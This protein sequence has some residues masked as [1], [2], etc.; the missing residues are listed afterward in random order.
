MVKKSDPSK[1]PSD[2]FFALLGEEHIHDP[3]QI[4]TVEANPTIEGKFDKLT[5]E[6][7]NFVTCSFFHIFRIR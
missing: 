5:I 2:E 7:V 4:F 6:N 1:K 3:L